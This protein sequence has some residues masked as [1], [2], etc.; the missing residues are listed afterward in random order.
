M[1][2]PRKRL[3]VVSVLVFLIA[4][5]MFLSYLGM[6]VEAS[7]NT[8]LTPFI[9]E[10]TAINAYS[11]P[12]PKWNDSS[13]FASNTNSDCDISTVKVYGCVMYQ[14]T[15]ISQVD[16]TAVTP[17][18]LPQYSSKLLPNYVNEYGYGYAR[19]RFTVNSNQP[20]YLYGLWSPDSE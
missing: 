7:G 1:I 4:V 3:K 8:Q 11:D 19:L 17:K 6:N 9:Y 14:G 10:G 15:I 12:R 13:S 20:K 2:K 16:C 5:S 18:P